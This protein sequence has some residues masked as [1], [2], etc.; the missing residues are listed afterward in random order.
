MAPA[1]DGAFGEEVM[2]LVPAF[3]NNGGGLHWSKVTASSLI[4]LDPF[5]KVVEGEGEPERT[6]A[7][8]HI[9]VRRVKKDAKALFHAHPPYITALSCL[10]DPTLEQISQNSARFKDRVAYDNEY[11]GAASEIEEG[12]RLAKVMGDK[13]I[14]I[15]CNHGVLVAADTAHAAFDEIYYLE[16]ACMTQVLAMGAVGR[17]KL[18]ML[19]EEVA[20]MTKKYI[21]DEMDKY[22][23]KHFSAYW[24]K[25]T[26]E[27]SDVFE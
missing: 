10:A 2:L 13:D 24:N 17:D 23:W 7:C 14:L 25:Y 20:E 3:V 5:A 18:N 26:E 16:R 8:I 1:R 6:G 4:G 27:G 9:G 11:N 15:M 19:T 22:A 12:E 21:V